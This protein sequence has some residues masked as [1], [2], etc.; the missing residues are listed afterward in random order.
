MQRQEE[1]SKHHTCSSQGLGSLG[2]TYPGHRC[3]PFTRAGEPA[4]RSEQVQG[5]PAGFGPDYW[6]QMSSSCIR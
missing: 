4:P 2:Q 1:P 6:L 5:V 3:L